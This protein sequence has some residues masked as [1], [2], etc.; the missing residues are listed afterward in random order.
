MGQKQQ[1]TTDSLVFIVDHRTPGHIYVDGKPVFVQ[2]LQYQLA[3]LLAEHPGV[4][5]PYD[6]VYRELWGR[7]NRIVEPNQI[8]YQARQLRKAINESVNHRDK[9]IKTITKHGLVLDLSPDQV[10]VVPLSPGS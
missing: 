8:H 2:F 5:V 9:L 7:K 6:T 10:L 1:P 4:C 3:T